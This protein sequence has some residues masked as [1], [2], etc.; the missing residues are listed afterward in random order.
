MLLSYWLYTSYHIAKNI[1]RNS[2]LNQEK[3]RK[4]SEKDILLHS[5]KFSNYYSSKELIDRLK[6]SIRGI[7]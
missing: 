3:M 1:L 6:V 7:L 2:L 4:F 5:Y